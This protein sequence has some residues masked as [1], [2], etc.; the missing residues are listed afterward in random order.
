MRL[1]ESFQ[2]AEDTQ[3]EAN[4]VKCDQDWQVT[5]AITEV[6]LNPLGCIFFEIRSI[7]LGRV[8]QSK[9]HSCRW[10]VLDLRKR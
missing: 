2:S 1:V 4:K 3:I 7:M 6:Q 8:F 5:V 10:E 9:I